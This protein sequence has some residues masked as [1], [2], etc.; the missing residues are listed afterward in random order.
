MK[1]GLCKQQTKKATKLGTLLLYQVNKHNR[2]VYHQMNKHNKTLYHHMNMYH[3]MNALYHH[4]NAILRRTI[5][6]ILQ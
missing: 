4:M 2:K 3:H 6:K 5:K 1:V